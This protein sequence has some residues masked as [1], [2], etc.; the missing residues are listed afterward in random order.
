MPSQSPLCRPS[1]A[2][3][4]PTSAFDRVRHLQLR[5]V[6]LQ[7]AEARG[8]CS[9]CRAAQGQ[10]LRRRRPARRTLPMVLPHCLARPASNGDCPSRTEVTRRSA[11]GDGQE[12]GSRRSPRPSRQP[13]RRLRVRR[14]GEGR[15]LRERP[16]RQ[17]LRRP[18]AASVAC[19]GGIGAVGSVMAVSSV[20]SRDG[21]CARGSGAGGERPPR[22][23]RWIRL[24][25]TVT[26]PENAE[27]CS[28][29]LVSLTFFGMSKT[30]TPVTWLPGLI[31]SK[32]VLCSL[33]A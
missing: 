13:R 5:P 18:A 31:S 1:S 12:D 9:P 32:K 27:S 23:E 10:R 14:V 29:S 15:L 2:R 6:A 7:L 3:V 20:N 33:L 16:D 22:V 21:R 24:R 4:A 28:S 19:S 17:G 26:P 30:N 11:A 25:A 8:R